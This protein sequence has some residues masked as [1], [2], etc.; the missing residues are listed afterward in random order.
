[1]R[2][3]KPVALLLVIVGGINWLLVGLF[4]FDLVAALTGSTF[5]EV[6]PISTVVYVLVGVAAIAMVP[7]L[8]SWLTTPARLLSGSDPVAPR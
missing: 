1:M 2:Y 8:R 7:V 6:N 5:G 3:L 4:G